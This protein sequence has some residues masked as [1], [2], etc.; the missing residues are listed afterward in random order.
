MTLDELYRL[1][2][3]NHVQAQGIVDTLQEPLVVLDKEFLVVNANPAFFR[4]FKAERE[5][6]LGR[7]LFDLGDG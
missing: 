1:L 6:T 4:L 3:S 5:D 7:S 2:R